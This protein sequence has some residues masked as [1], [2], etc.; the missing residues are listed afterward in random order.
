MPRGNTIVSEDNRTVTVTT[1][2]SKERL[3]VSVD[4]HIETISHLHAKVHEGKC[5]SVSDYDT[6][7]K[8]IAWD[9]VFEVGSVMAH[10]LYEATTSMG[11]I[12][13]IYESPTYTG[14]TAKS[15][16]NH[17]RSSILTPTM[18]VKDDVTV[19][20]DGTL[21][22][23]VSLSGTN[24]TGSSVASNLEWILAQNT[25]YLMRITSQG[26]SNL[27]SGRAIWYEEDV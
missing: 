17:N 12:I 21:I 4:E 23:V 10:L 6:L 19:T 11:V 2:G 26:N 8:S 13:E 18:V 22:D 16:Y 5:F 7:N 14:G 1:D 24:Q 25:D 20:A 27:I 9:L 3:D 15:S